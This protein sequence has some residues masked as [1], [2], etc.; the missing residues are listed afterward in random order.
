MAQAD[1]SLRT[2]IET[3]S[4]GAMEARGLTLVWP[5]VP[6]AQSKPPI[7]LAALDICTPSIIYRGSLEELMELAPRI[8]MEVAAPG[9]PELEVTCTPA[10]LPWSIWSALVTMD[11]FIWSFDR[12]A[13]EPVTSVRRCVPYPTTTTSSRLT[14]PSALSLMLRSDWPLTAT[15]WVCIPM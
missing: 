13:T 10:I 9:A 7:S 14:P 2:S 1:A 15:F 12:E 5:L 11:S 3:M 8:R 6:P 4:L